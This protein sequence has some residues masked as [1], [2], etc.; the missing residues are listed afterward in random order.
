MSNNKSSW[1]R[2]FVVVLSVG[3]GVGVGARLDAG[4]VGILLLWRLEKRFSPTT[5]KSFCECSKE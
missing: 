4:A 2:Q 5:R 1:K 3:A